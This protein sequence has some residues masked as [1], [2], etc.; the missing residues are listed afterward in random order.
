MKALTSRQQEA[1]DF[2]ATYIDKN[3]YA[4]SVRELCEAL[5]GIG[6][7]A[8]QGHLIALEVKGFI[9]R[10]PSIARAITVNKEFAGA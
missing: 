9:T 7:A 5:G 3:G 6:T 8:G 1:L 4:P 2:L 10:Q